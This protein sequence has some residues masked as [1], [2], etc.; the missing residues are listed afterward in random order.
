MPKRAD[1]DA[2]E[3]GSGRDSD[4]GADRARRPD[5]S[6]GAARPAH[7]GTSRRLSGARAAVLAR[8]QVEELLGLPVETISGFARD[9]G[10]FTV[11]LEVVEVE[12]V[13]STTDILAT[14][15]VRITPDGE[16]D[17]YERVARYYRNQAGGGDE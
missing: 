2:R 13:P 8:E 17:G 14:Y 10:G 1:A 5:A 3:R 15:R 16:L 6:N 4:G 12:R 11:M 9:E 7:D